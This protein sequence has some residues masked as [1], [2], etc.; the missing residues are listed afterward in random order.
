MTFY[1]INT[2]FDKLPRIFICSIAN[3][4]RI[5]DKRFVKKVHIFATSITKFT[6]LT[7]F[8]TIH[9][10]SIVMYIVV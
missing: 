5:L 10:I 4:V 1:R 8:I 7:C 6:S 9:H 2:C 3:A